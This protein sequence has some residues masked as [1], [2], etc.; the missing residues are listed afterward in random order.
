M[1]DCLPREKDERVAAMRRGIIQFYLKERGFGYVRVPA[2]GE[3]YHFLK[4][5]L[6]EEVED[7]EEIEFE[8]K[9]TKQGLKANNIRRVK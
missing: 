9:E 1:G 8:V 4:K 5:H 3:E 6:T 7:K 2:T